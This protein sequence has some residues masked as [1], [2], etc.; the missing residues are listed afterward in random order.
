M[1]LINIQGK[2]INRE[3]VAMLNSYEPILVGGVEIPRTEIVFY[4]TLNTVVKGKPEEIAKLLE[5]KK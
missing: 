5:D 1:K 2:I 3:R 4:T